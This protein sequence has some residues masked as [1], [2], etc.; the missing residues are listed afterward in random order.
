MLTLGQLCRFDSKRFDKRPGSVYGVSGGCYYGS[1]ALDYETKRSYQ[2]SLNVFDE[3]GAFDNATVVIS[4]TDSN[5]PP[6]F[7]SSL[8][9]FSIQENAPAQTVVG[10]LVAVDTD[11]YQ[12]R[13]ITYSIVR[14]NDLDAFGVLSVG[15]DGKLVVDSQGAIDFERQSHYSLHISA[16][17]NGPESLSGFC[18]VTVDVTD[19]NE[20]P[21]VRPS[22]FYIAENI[23]IGSSVF[24]TSALNET[25]TGA[26]YASDPDKNDSLSFAMSEPSTT[27]V[28]DANTGAISTSSLLNF[29]QNS[30]YVVYIS[31]TDSGNLTSTAKMEI[32]VLDRNDAPVIT[33]TEFTVPENPARNF[34]IG[35]IAVADDD[36]NQ[37]HFFTLNQTTLVLR[38]GSVV[39]R[40]NND[41]VS[42]EM[43]SGSISVLDGNVF[44]FESVNRLVLLVTVVDNGNPIMQTT[45]ALTINVTNE[46]EP[47]SFLPSTTTWSI[48]ENS[49]GV[50][51]EALAIDPDANTSSIWGALSYYKRD[52]GSQGEDNALMSASGEVKIQIPFNYEVQNSVSIGIA[53]VD[54][55]GLICS[56][57][58]L[59]S[60]ENVN[61]PPIID[62]KH[63]WVPESVNGNLDWVRSDDGSHARVS[64]GILRITP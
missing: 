33:S 34:V 15:G 56:G 60:I 64:F 46:N 7:Q 19:A 44:D 8:Y 11:T 31:V 50:V 2:L 24:T 36:F 53:A 1:G 23:V 13:T 55:G 10:D 3:R 48:P 63:Y 21:Q 35:T 6:V 40:P 49:I 26:A 39:S 61:E 37:H 51:G 58:I 62:V 59:I 20:A 27:F 45:S 57:N 16:T 18:T 14:G 38:D 47:C 41:A 12:N 4:V 25:A 54:G 17:D 22:V 42:V 29:E 9:N 43:T 32:L 52:T 30:K 5:E 28:I